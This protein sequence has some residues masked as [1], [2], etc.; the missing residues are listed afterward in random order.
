MNKR[1]VS[2]RTSKGKY[3]FYV[4]EKDNPLDCFIEEAREIH[5]VNKGFPPIAS[6]GIAKVCCRFMHQQN[7]KGVIKFSSSQLANFL[8]EYVKGLFKENDDFVEKLAGEKTSSEKDAVVSGERLSI[9]GKIKSAE[10]K[11]LPSEKL[12]KSDEG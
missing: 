5:K 9:R 12:G 8:E 4:E 1:K 10:A 7:K 2:F 6:L 11:K 3:S